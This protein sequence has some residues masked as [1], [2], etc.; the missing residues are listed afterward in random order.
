MKGK[1]RITHNAKPIAL[2]PPLSDSNFEETLSE[3]R[4]SRAI[5]A[6][7]QMQQKAKN[8]GIDQMSVEDID[9]E[10]QNTRKKKK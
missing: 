6:V 5:D 8:E 7:K 9:A 10:I 1:V 3:L 2:V 4:K